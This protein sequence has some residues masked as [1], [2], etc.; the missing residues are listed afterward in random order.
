MNWYLFT[1][2]T[3]LAWLAIAGLCACIVGGRSDRCAECKRQREE[4]EKAQKP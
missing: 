3:L 4:S 2:W 1:A